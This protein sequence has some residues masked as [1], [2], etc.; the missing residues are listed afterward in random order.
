MRTEWEHGWWEI[1]SA[2]PHVS[3]R[4]AVVGDYIGWTERSD[5]VLRRREVA[6]T[7]VPLIINF[8]APYRLFSGATQGGDAVARSSFVA[9]LYDTWAAVE[10]PT[11]SCAMQVNFTPFAAFQLLRTPLSLLHNSSV[12]CTT[13]FG[14]VGSA[15]VEQ[16]G[17]AVDWP[18]RFAL[19]DTFLRARLTN[20]PTIPA[21]L[22]WCWDAL[23]SSDGRIPIAELVARTQWS[24][25]RLINAFRMYAGLPPSTIAGLTRFERAVSVIDAQTSM[26]GRWSALAFDC[27]YA[28]QSHLIR[29]FSRFAGCTPT[30]YLRERLAN[31]G[32][33][34]ALGID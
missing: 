31:G 28:D 29:D 34:V 9:G 23:A 17:N 13:V 25:R 26:T 22:Y 33:A 8:G 14:A 24:P 15:L 20:A 18:A 21:E 5:V 11:F 7:M 30:A 6:S 27:G 4:A 2:T 3:L 19:L 10:G 32:G 12:E 16:L 1:A